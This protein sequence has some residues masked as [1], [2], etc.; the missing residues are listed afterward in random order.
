MG[1]VR[2]ARTD[3]KKLLTFVTVM[4]LSGSLHAQ[5]SKLYLVF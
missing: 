3:R 1:D 4:L 5:D 2:R